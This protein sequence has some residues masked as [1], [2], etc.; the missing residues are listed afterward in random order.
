MKK[1]LLRKL[2]SFTL[3]EILIATALFAILV[4]IS[5]VILTTIFNSLSKVSAYQSVQESSRKAME[6]IANEVKG[7]DLTL[8]QGN[9]YG[10]EIASYNPTGPAISLTDGKYSGPV[11][12]VFKPDGTKVFK[13]KKRLAGGGY[14]NISLGEGD[15]TEC[16]SSATLGCA[17]MM[18]EVPLS[19]PNV[20]VQELTFSGYHKNTASPTNQPY[21]TIETQVQSRWQQKKAEKE[22]MILR[23]T[24]IPYSIYERS[25]DTTEDELGWPPVDRVGPTD[26]S[27]LA[28]PSGYVA[29]GAGHYT[30]HEG[31]DDNIDDFPWLRCRQLPDGVSLGATTKIDYGTDTGCT[32]SGH[33]DMG[34]HYV[35]IEGGHN[36]LIECWDDVE[37]SHIKWAQLIGAKI[38]YNQTQAQYQDVLFEPLI[39]PDKYVMIGAGHYTSYS[40]AHVEENDR[41]YIN[42]AKLVMPGGGDWEFE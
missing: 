1:P 33:Q 10:F 22:T 6:M 30:I 40:D 2:R 9:F 38:D 8:Q 29:T 42:C 11:L 37:Q 26:N 23:T 12:K 27:P 20:N 13:L 18:D 28:C 7:A 14:E 4:A 35:V 31:D 24:A 41:E 36:P 15:G 32:T 16:P 21:V 17:L 25:D 39:C 19:S 5:M 3:V 34:S